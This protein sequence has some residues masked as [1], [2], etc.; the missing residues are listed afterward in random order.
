MTFFRISFVVLLI[1][2]AAAS[3]LIVLSWP[4]YPDFDPDLD[5][6]PVIEM[7]SGEQCQYALAKFDIKKLGGQSS[8]LFSK[9]NQEQNCIEIWQWESWNPWNKQVIDRSFLV[10]YSSAWGPGDYQVYLK[11]D[12][13]QNICLG[14]LQASP[15][16]QGVELRWIPQD[17]K[18]E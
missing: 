8:V 4:H 2:L 17:S 18:E 13:Q 11:S 15:G 10:L 16:L 6:P 12:G 5:E 9:V 3:L 1:L 7:V 14:R